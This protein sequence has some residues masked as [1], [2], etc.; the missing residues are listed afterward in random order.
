MRDAYAPAGSSRS[1][2]VSRRRVLG[3]VAA[4]TL[5]ALAGCSGDS[6]SVPDPVALDAG[7]S[8]DQCNMQIDAH[9]GPVGQSYYLDDPPEDLPADRED[10]RAHFCSAWCTYTYVLERAGDGPEPAGTYL[11]DYSTVEYTVSEEGGATVISAHLG[12]GAFAR[13]E[14]LTHA[15]ESDVQGAMGASLV[16]FSNDEDVTAFIDEYGGTRVAHEDVTREMVANM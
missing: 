16:G 14:E 2:H 9:P 3:T 15:V 13:A 11:T 10:G 5:A 6:E 4:G 1:G 8:C 7:Q 12:V